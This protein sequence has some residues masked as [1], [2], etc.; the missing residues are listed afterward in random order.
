MPIPAKSAQEHLGETAVFQR[1]PVA[2]DPVLLHRVG[3]TGIPCLS[4]TPTSTGSK[5]NPQ[6]KLHHP[7]HPPASHRQQ[8]V[9]G[10]P[11]DC[12]FFDVRED[13]PVQG[14]RSDEATRNGGDGVRVV[15]WR[16]H[17][18]CRHQ[19]W[20]VLAV[21]IIDAKLHELGRRGDP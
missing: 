16:P 11:Q 20:P 15:R 18:R 1:K 12:V 17:S 6:G 5:R 2:W 14:K 3:A 10:D 4:M 19:L 21:R 9:R 7:L 13:I 8:I